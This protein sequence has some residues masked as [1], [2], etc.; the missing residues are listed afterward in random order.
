VS[1]FLLSGVIYDIIVV[2]FN[3]IRRFFYHGKV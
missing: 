2:V 1:F 3:T